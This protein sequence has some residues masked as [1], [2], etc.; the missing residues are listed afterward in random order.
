M[1]YFKDFLISV[2]EPEPVE[3][4]LFAG[5]EAEIFGLAPGL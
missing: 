2:A 1:F 3:R 5:A 4:L